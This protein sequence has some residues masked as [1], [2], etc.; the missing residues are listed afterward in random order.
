MLNKLS[1]S[2]AALAVLLAVPACWHGARFPR[3]DLS[4]FATD[5]VTLD[6]VA[7]FCWLAETPAQRAQGLMF[8]TEAQLAP[9]ADGTPR[10]MLF[11]F[12]SPDNVA[13]FMRDTFVP[14]DLAYVRADGTVA[15]VHELE[16]L[17]ETPVPSGEPVLYALE[18]YRGT[19]AANGV[20]VGST[21]VIPAAAGG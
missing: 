4:G 15:E 8:A 16:P 19:L 1:T 18:V 9:L 5:T 7:F 17:D 12:P 11:V 10:G 21:L 13:F 3:A 20:G 2:G 6:G 14:L